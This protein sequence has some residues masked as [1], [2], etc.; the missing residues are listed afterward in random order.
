MQL[1]LVWPQVLL[2]LVGHLLLE[3]GQKQEVLLLVVG[4]EQQELQLVGVKLH[5]HEQGHALRY[6]QE[7]PLQELPPKL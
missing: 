3:R 2:E 4:P 1:E 6:L 7:L 5:H